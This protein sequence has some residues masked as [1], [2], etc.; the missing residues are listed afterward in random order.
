[1]STEKYLKSNIKIDDLKNRFKEGSIPLQ[2]DFAN[3]IDI[4]D[5]GRRA[6]G[7]APDQTNNQNSALELN[8]NSGLA[9]KV[10]TNGGIIVDE[11]GVSI[12]TG[13]GIKVDSSGISIDPTNVLPRGMIVMFSGNS[14][15]H[16]WEL[17]DGN[18]GTPNLIDR[19]ILGGDFAGINGKSN[20]TYSG[21]KN[22]KSFSF[23]SD[24]ATLNINGKTTDSSLSINQIPNHNHLSGM[25]IDTKDNNKYGYHEIKKPENL[26]TVPTANN[27]RNAFQYHSS[28]VIGSTGV[29][30]Q[31]SQETHNHDI[32]LKNTGKHSHNSRI[33]VP[34]YILAFIMKN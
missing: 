24:E 26:W 19:F 34:Y 23:N 11:N 15:P 12:K 27:T 29:V 25:V 16:G 21:L 18:N 9:V 28:G 31:N 3:L 6:V 33:T 22:S 14:A 32:D 30:A 2:T 7:K 10:N 5:I 20:I 4:A 8:D 17:C 1:M 13:N